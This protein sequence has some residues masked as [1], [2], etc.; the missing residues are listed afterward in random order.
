MAEKILLLDPDKLPW[1]VVLHRILEREGVEAVMCVVRI[2]DRWHTTWSNE[3][4]GGLAM[5]AMKLFRDV[6]DFLEDDEEA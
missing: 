6:S 2:D 5:G 3:A 1:R 4:L